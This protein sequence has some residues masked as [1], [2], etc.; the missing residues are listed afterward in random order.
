MSWIQ[1]THACL[2][3]EPLSLMVICHTKLALK[4]MTCTNNTG[5]ANLMVRPEAC[6]KKSRCQSI[7][8]NEVTGIAMSLVNEVRGKPHKTKW[9]PVESSILLNCPCCLGTLMVSNFDTWYWGT[10]QKKVMD[11]EVRLRFQTTVPNASMVATTYWDYLTLT[12]RK[13]I[14]YSCLHQSSHFPRAW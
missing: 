12:S 2:I 8:H 11:K 1:T 9:F 4:E 5:L 10:F 14:Q 6:K 13:W 7:F 3:C